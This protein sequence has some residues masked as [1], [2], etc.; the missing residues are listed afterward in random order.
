MENSKRGSIPMQE[1]LR[2]SK[3]QGASTLAELK[4]MKNVPY[5]SVVGSI[6]YDVRCSRPD[7]VFAQNITS[8]VSCYTDARY[9]TDADDLKSQTGYVFVLNGDASKEAVWVRKFISRLGVV[10]TIEEP[11]KMYCDNIRAITI[12]NESGITKGARHYHAKVHY[13][14]KVIDTTFGAASS[15]PFGGSSVYGQKPAFGG[16]DRLQHQVLLEAHL[17]NDNLLPKA[18]RLAR[19]LLELELLEY[20]S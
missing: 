12:A 9:L 17:H 18:S 16:F 4:R 7:V 19:Q 3:S 15:S 20:G 6:M 2:L 8:R 14:R 10:P 5:A 11:I 13:L 1:N